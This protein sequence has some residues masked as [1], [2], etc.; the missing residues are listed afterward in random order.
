MKSF[1][2]LLKE[3]FTKIRDQKF[4]SVFVM[5][6]VFLL[7]TLEIIFIKDPM[8]LNGV[9]IENHNFCLFMMIFMNMLIITVDRVNKAFI[10]R[11]ENIDT[12]TIL[13]R[14][15]GKLK[16]I[17]A[18]MVSVFIVTLI[19]SLVLLGL[20]K[21]VFNVSFTGTNFINVISA[22]TLSFLMCYCLTLV[23]NNIH[24]FGYMIIY[25]ILI[26]LG[27]F[28]FPIEIM[29]EGAR[30]VAYLL[31]TTHAVKLMQ[32]SWN[33]LSLSTGNSLKILGVYTLIFAIVGLVLF[34][35]KINNKYD[36]N[37]K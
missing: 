11:K 10:W 24:I 21:L 28:T 4:I 34:F 16:F 20:S 32:Y 25:V 23:F 12:D 17:L 9:K 31:P 2:T 33:G 13:H 5:A 29:N 3:E 7:Y 22:Y 15:K 18:N 19:S 26:T 8:M 36:A 6:V 35:G 30:K 14:K 1:N 27:G 37:K